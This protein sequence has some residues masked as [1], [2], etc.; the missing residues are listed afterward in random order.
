[1]DEKSIVLPDTLVAQLIDNA[2]T[3]NDYL[4][5]EFQDVLGSRNNLRDRLVNEK[6]IRQVKRLSHT[7][8][9]TFSIDG[10]HVVEIDRASAY[11][12][13]CAVCVSSNEGMNGQSSC[14]ALL[15]HV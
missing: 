2:A 4:Q 3:L 7:L 11:S 8:P 1:M 9:S 6:T 5:Q 10:A 12:V 15:P 14:L 13:S